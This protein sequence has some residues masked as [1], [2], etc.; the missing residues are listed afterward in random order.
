MQD[1]EFVAGPAGHNFLLFKQSYGTGACVLELADNGLAA[2]KDG[3]IIASGM[4]SDSYFL[5][6][7]E[8]D[9]NPMAAIPEPATMML[10]GTGAL[11][12]LGWLRRR[13][14]R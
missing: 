3:V 9:A 11:G 4:R 10:L 14:M 1:I 12:A 5:A 7:F 8:V 6:G 13:R 2:V